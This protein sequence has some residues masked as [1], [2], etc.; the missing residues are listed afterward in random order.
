VIE[1]S[2]LL[3]RRADPRRRD[4]SEIRDF[5]RRVRRE[6]ALY[7]HVPLPHDGL[8]WIEMARIAT[9]FISRAQDRF[10]GESIDGTEPWSES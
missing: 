5:Q 6:V 7:G 10:V 4:R 8:V 3:E 1:T 2:P 9:P